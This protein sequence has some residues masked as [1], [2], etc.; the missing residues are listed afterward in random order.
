M[1][2]ALV[3][4]LA[5][6]LSAPPALAQGTSGL[7]VTP[8]G[9]YV[10]FGELAEIPG[11]RGLT[12]DD[13]WLVGAQVGLRLTSGLSLFGNVAH[14]RTDFRYE[15]VEGDVVDVVSGELGYWLYDAGIELRFGQG[16][17]SPFLQA[18]GGAVRYT[19]ERD[20]FE[21]EGKTDVQFNFGAGV[22]FSAGPVGLRIMLKDYLTSLDWTDFDAFR[23]QVQDD[24]VDR[25][26]IANNLALTVGLRI[27]F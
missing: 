16:G 9:G 20:D 12:N 24:D 14:T 10:W 25:S 13:N 23:Q 15:D 1:K 17:L 2:K 18:G 4:A 5:V 27:G 11:G 19:A 22:D 6:L 8:Y 7:S 3:G 26:R 21:S